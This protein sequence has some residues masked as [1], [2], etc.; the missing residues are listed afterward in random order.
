M[1]RGENGVTDC[2]STWRKRRSP[3]PSPATA[4]VRRN[5]EGHVGLVIGR[6][7]FN[8]FAVRAEELIEKNRPELVAAVTQMVMHSDHFN[9]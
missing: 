6:T 2:S 5:R 4:W 8:V 1:A 9:R 7:K 3:K